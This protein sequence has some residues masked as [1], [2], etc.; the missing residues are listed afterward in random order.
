M[1]EWI[2]DKNEMCGREQEGKTDFNSTEPNWIELFCAVCWIVWC[3]IKTRNL[4]NIGDIFLLNVQFGSFARS[5]GPFTHWSHLFT[6]RF[7]LQFYHGCLFFIW[8]LD[9]IKY[10][11]IKLTT[12]TASV[13]NTNARTSDI[14]HFYL[15]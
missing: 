13:F 12:S 8:S 11:K 9:H 14:A 7:T 15:N 2:H 10:I 3:A 5:F 1:C 4:T 6:Y